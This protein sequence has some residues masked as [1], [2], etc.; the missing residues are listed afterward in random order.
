MHKRFWK[1]EIELVCNSLTFIE[2]Y[3]LII[4][5]YNKISWTILYNYCN[6]LCRSYMFSF[7]F[8]FFTTDSRLLFSVANSSLKLNHLQPLDLSDS[9]L[10]FLVSVSIPHGS[11]PILFT[12]KSSLS[13]QRKIEVR[14]A[15][16]EISST[17]SSSSPFCLS[18]LAISCCHQARCSVVVSLNLGNGNPTTSSIFTYLLPDRTEVSMR[19]VFQLLQYSLLFPPYSG[20]AEPFCEPVCSCKIDL[21]FKVHWWHTDSTWIIVT[22]SVEEFF[23]LKKDL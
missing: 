12:W 13:V 21:I 10:Y 11:R 1:I 22:Q 6:F 7:Q 15:K 2:D 17:F 9:S 4:H 16:N 8:F 14:L 3:C 5:V 19:T 23:S 20:F 18:H